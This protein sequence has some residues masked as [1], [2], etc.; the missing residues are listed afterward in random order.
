MLIINNMLIKQAEEAKHLGVVIENKLSWDKHIQRVV[1]KMGYIFSV[2]KRCAKYLTQQ[3]IQA[4]V[5]SYQDYC[6][7][8]WSN[9]SLGNIRELQLVRNKASRVALICGLRA[10][11]E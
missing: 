2:I 7:M 10:N 5:L 8:V 3:V 11:V 4:L 1:T 9:T 6:S